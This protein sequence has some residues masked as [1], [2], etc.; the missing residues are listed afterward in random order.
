[1]DPCY[2]FIDFNTWMWSKKDERGALEQL[3][4][5]KE[6][7]SDASTSGNGHSPL[8]SAIMNGYFDLAHALIDAGANLSH[9][10]NDKKNAL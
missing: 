3:S 10:S 5:C 6:G 1:M 9:R 4:R 7:V 2:N 8:Q